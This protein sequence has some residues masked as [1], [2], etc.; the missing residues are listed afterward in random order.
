MDATQR[1][2]AGLRSR[3]SFLRN[4]ALVSAGGVLSPAVALAATPPE[5][6]ERPRQD[7]GVTVLN[8]Y[9][10]QVPVSFIIDDSTCLVNMAYYG[11]P[12]FME[13]WEGHRKKF[14]NTDWKSWPQ[15]IPDA[16]VRR[17][18]TWCHENKVKGKYSIVP[19]PA[20]VGWV[21]RVMPGWSRKELR[22]SIKLV[23]EL[24]MPD[25][26]IHPEMA[27]HTR[28]ID[29]KTGRPLEQKKDGS[30]WM[31][32]GGWTG[33]R[34][35][36]EIA[37]YIA[38][39]LQMLKNVDLPC[40]GFTT[41]G[42]FGNPRQDRLSQAGRQAVTAV[43][44]TELPHYF[45]YVVD[46]GLKTEPRVEFAKGLMS[47]SPECI[48]NVPSCT[49]DWFGGWTGIDYGAEEAGI[50]RL[51]TK[52]GTRGRMVECIEGGAPAAMLCHWPGMYCNGT[53]VG[54]RIFQGAVERIN[55][56]YGER[57]RWMKVSEMARSWAAKELTEIIIADEGIRL[58]APFES[59]GFTLKMEKPP[60][61]VPALQT[62][63]DRKPVPLRGARR[64]AQSLPPHHWR[65]S[66]D[67]QELCITLPKGKSIVQWQK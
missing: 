25:W 24:M 17:F 4:A 55:N 1:G 63:T 52:D 57:V 14:R 59:P 44:G 26:D 22:E 53:E 37:N 47:D 45:K 31:E 43:F 16:F 11:L 39:S 38:Y 48:V 64:G 2:E 23:Q 49:G 27:T 35:V 54:Y 12:Q 41:P 13:A 15:E 28:V 7:K 66:G 10:G 18:G 3:R 58:H 21:D 62:A 20:C 8:P 19:F 36:D 61:G 32:N 34:S 50:D 51:I 9:G 40:E 29:V 60:K 67:T 33:E 5:P 42:G 30:Y 46:K 56:R 6:G 65:Q